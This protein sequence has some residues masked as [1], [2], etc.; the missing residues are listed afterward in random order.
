MSHTLGFNAEEVLVDTFVLIKGG[1]RR[2]GYWLLPAAVRHIQNCRGLQ[3]IFSSSIT[4][5]DC[6]PFYGSG[7]LMFV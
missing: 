5:P 7:R 4:V 6:R 1:G 3:R 2:V